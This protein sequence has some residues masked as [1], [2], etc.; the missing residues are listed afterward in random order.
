MAVLQG[1]EKQPIDFQ[2]GGKNIPPGQKNEKIKNIPRPPPILAKHI[3]LF[4]SRDRGRFGWVVWFR[5][6]G[7]VSVG[8]FGFD[9]VVW[10][11]LSCL[12]RWLSFLLVVGCWFR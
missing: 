5:L 10:F 6:G 11:R 9:W 12:C 1:K 2:N 8:W 3:F 7:L 4:F